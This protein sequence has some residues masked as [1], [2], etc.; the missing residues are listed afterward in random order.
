[1]AN[2]SVN[3]RSDFYVYELYLRGNKKGE[4]EG[5]GGKGVAVSYICNII[6][7]VQGRGGV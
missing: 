4:S 7:C 3:K 2:L 5:R 1:M 6:T